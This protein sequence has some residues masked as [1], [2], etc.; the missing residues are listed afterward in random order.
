[1]ADNPTNEGGGGPDT[2]ST[3]ASENTSRRHSADEANDTRDHCQQHAVD[4][5]RDLDPELLERVLKAVEPALL[6]GD[7]PEAFSWTWLEL[8]EDDPRRHHALVLAALAWW[9]A[10]TAFG[11][12][13]PEPVIEREIDY[14]MKRAAVDISQGADWREQANRP[15]RRAIDRRRA[16]PITPALCTAAG[17]RKRLSVRHPLPDLRTVRCA[18]HGPETGAAT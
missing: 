5:D 16:E 11:M 7:L 17:C 8:A 13:V 6:A 3:A 18:Q 15:G 1:M 12:E 9:S 10:T 4:A 14:R 2:P